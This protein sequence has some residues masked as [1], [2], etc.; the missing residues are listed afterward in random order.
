MRIRLDL[1]AELFGSQADVN[2]WW[3]IKNA[4]STIGQLMLDVAAYFSLDSAQI[5]LKCEGYLLLAPQLVKDVIEDGYTLQVVNFNYLS[6]NLTPANSKKRAAQ[7]TGAD[8]FRP[9]FSPLSP[10][11]YPPSDNFN[12]TISRP[13]FSANPS[14]SSTSDNDTET[15]SSSGLHSGS[16]SDVSSV[17]SVSD[18]SDSES[19]SSSTSE[20]SSESDVSEQEHYVET[21]QVSRQLPFNAPP[22]D[23]SPLKIKTKQQRKRQNKRNRK[24]M[25]LARNDVVQNIS[26]IYRNNVVA[27]VDAPKAVP[28]EHIGEYGQLNSIDMSEL[29]IGDVVAWRVLVLAPSGSPELTPWQLRQVIAIDAAAQTI[30]FEALNLD[31]YLESCWYDDEG[32]KVMKVSE[33]LEDHVLRPD[34]DHPLHPA[35]SALP[36]LILSQADAIDDLRLASRAS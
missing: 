30:T 3:I 32:E 31:A 22:M 16:S 2:A 1:S 17:S 24:A 34:P 35:C 15:A 26:R 5:A 33:W 28:E 18:S 25:E 4:E 20:S 13:K 14:S 19:S 12:A 11:P 7:R 6:F 21:Q 23:D 36:T 10:S 8:K 9:T 29:D 27:P